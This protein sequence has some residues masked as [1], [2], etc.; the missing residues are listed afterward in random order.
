MTAKSVLMR[1]QGIR[2][3]ARAPL[4][5]YRSK[6]AKKIP[7]GAASHPA[8]LFSAP[9]YYLANHSSRG[10]LSSAL[11]KDTTSELSG[12]FSTLSLYAERQARK[13]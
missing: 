4:A 6:E 2:P 3:G 5:P 7:R 11:P 1:P 12:L 13:M 8:P 9:M 10:I